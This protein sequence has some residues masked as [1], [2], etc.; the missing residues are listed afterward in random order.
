MV[1]LVDAPVYAPPTASAVTQAKQQFPSLATP[2]DVARLSHVV[3]APVTI[4]Q[5]A[6]PPF[7]SAPH[8]D[9]MVSR[10]VRLSDC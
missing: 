7:L 2:G 9:G 8:M 3:P 6:G 4:P 5:D 10:S 1:H